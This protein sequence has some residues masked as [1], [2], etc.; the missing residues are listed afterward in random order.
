MALSQISQFFFIK[1]TPG[2]KS[3]CRGKRASVH[4]HGWRIPQLS[5]FA[6]PVVKLTIL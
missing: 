4:F 2:R 3:S 6:V 1:A 5:G